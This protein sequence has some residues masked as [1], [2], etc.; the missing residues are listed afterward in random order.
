MKIGFFQFEPKFLDVEENINQIISELEKSQ[1]FDLIVLPELANSGYLFK[2]KE[3][4]EQVAEEIPGGTFVSHLE[5]I[6]KSKNAYIVAGVAEK[7]G[8]IFFNSSVLLGPEGYVSTYRKLHLFDREKLFFEPGNKPLE[9]YDIGKAKVGLMICFDWIFPETVR[10]LALKGAEIICHSANLVLPYSQTA[11][12]ARSVENA[13][14][15][16][17]ANRIGTEKNDELILSFTGHSQI[18]SPKMKTL[19]KAEKDTTEIKIVEIDPELAK[20]KWIN[21]RN[22]LFEDRRVDYYAILT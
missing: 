19:A 22:N 18:T 21:E 8:S 9:V 3:E 10:V 7:K 6:C 15:T 1:T 4:L 14:F 11:M 5:S 20:N 16:I 12:L 13:V 17:T 2:K